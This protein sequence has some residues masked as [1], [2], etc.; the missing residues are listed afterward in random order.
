MFFLGNKNRMNQEKSQ[1]TKCSS[2]GNAVYKLDFQENLNVCPKCGFQHRMNAYDRVTMLVDTGSF[3]EIDNH[4]YSSDPLEFGDEYSEKLAGDIDKT[5][6][7]DAI[8]TGTAKI[9]GNFSAIAVMDF[10]FRGGSMGSAV[11]EKLSRLFELAISKKIPA[12]AV[13]ASGGARMQ[14]GVFALMQMAKTTACVN[15]MKDSKIPYIVVLTDPTTGG[16]SASFAS[17]GDITIAESKAVIG[18]SGARVI[19]QTIRQKL[20]DDFQSS[21]SL[22]KHGFADCVVQRKELRETL[23]KVLS[24][25]KGGKSL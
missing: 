15:K 3:K 1:W 25:F 21:E 23:I 24:F 10:F 8:L 9:G 7:S 20:P 14:E 16:V 22:L 18:F 17:L 2:C 6:L 11:G 4:I 13:T 5:G 19:E 12:I